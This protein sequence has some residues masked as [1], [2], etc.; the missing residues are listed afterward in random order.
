LCAYPSV[1]FKCI[2]VA[3][4]EEKKKKEEEKQKE[5]EEKVK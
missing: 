5:N 4:M 2:L 1:Y 3:K